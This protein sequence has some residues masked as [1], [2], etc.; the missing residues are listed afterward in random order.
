MLILLNTIGYYEVLVIIDE[1]QHER[2][3]KKISEN[4]EEISGNLLLKLSMSSPYGHEN[5]EYQRVYGDI[6]VAGQVYHL[7][8]QKVY[9][10]TLYVVCLKDAQTTKVKNVISDYSKTFAG[11]PQKSDTPCKTITSLAKFF[12]LDNA[13]VSK[14]Y[15]GW[16]VALPLTKLQNF[17]SFS[18]GSSVFHPPSFIA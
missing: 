12:T 10:D 18:T 9:R 11:Q 6:T 17:Y 16:C 4:E 1:Q 14:S 8:K 13:V 5:T 15:L 7:V 3:V 2:I